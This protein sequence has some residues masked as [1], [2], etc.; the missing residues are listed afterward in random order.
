[1]EKVTI[2]RGFYLDQYPVT[3]DQ[4]VRFLAVLGDHKK[5]PSA[6]QSLCIRTKAE[7]RGDHLPIGK[8]NGRYYVERGL[9]RH[10]ARSV[11]R[12]GAERYCQWLGKR[13][14]TEAEWEFAA[15]H[16]PKTGKDSVYPWGDTFK[17][18]HASCDEEECKDGFEETSPVGIFDG[19]RGRGDGSSAT[20]VHDLVGNVTEWTSDCY[21]RKHG[22]CKVPC[23]DPVVLPPCPYD[24][25][26]AKGSYCNE[27]S[28]GL[29]L[30][31]RQP[32]PLDGYGGYLG[33]RCAW[34]P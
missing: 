30:A 9:G 26:A 5:C 21:V 10:P 13:L 19:T 28:T 24:S 11:S 3:N 7:G 16:D 15:R 23:V 4:Y 2:T 12:E 25:W 22:W 6:Y 27:G 14:P 18:N 32:I 29:L 33:V 17:P 8:K 31:A 20:G 34:S 1:M